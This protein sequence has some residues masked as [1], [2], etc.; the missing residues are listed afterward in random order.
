MEKLQRY[1]MMGKRFIK[2]FHRDLMPLGI[3][4]LSFRK[5]SLPDELEI[6]AQTEDGIIMGL[7]H[8]KLPVEGI[9]FHPESILTNVGHQ[10]IENWLAL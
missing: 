7:R 2:S 5:G 8:K 9:Q 6:T 4:L 10:L 3:T 1:F